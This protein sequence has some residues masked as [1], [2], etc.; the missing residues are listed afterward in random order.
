MNYGVKCSVHT[1]K[2]CL[3][4]HNL[5]GHGPVKKLIILL[6]NRLARMK[7]AK[8]DCIGLQKNQSFACLVAMVSST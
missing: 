6:K 3:H 8:I 1:T 2:C 7:F 4:Q 5:F